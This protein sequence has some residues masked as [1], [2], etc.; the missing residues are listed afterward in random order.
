MTPAFASLED[1][2]SL[3]G[4]MPG[5]D[6]AAADAAR[7][8]DAVLTKP[9]GALGRLED[10]AVWYAG[11]RG[12]VRPRIE[13]PQV[14]VFAGNQTIVQKGELDNKIYQ[15]SKEGWGYRKNGIFVKENDKKTTQKLSQSKK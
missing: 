5:N 15:L 10:L 11:W 6:K 1:F 2:R 13:A 12:V 14:I 8:R 9:P 3:L 4:D 7:A